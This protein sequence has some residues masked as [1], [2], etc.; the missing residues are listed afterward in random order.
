MTRETRDR[1]KQLT[2]IFNY[3]F[4][5]NG[6]SHEQQLNKLQ[7]LRYVMGNPGDGLTAR[8]LFSL[9]ITMY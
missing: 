8:L 5:G 6:K 4:K 3:M 9:S 1:V 7:Q 2:P